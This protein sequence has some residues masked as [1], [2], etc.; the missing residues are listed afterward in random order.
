MFEFKSFRKFSKEIKS[1]ALFSIYD[2]FC[3]TFDSKTFVKDMFKQPED[4]D[5]MLNQNDIEKTIIKYVKFIPS[6]NSFMFEENDYKSMYKELVFFYKERIIEYLVSME[7]I[8]IGWN[9][10]NVCFITN[11]IIIA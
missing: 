6:T 8:V 9:N 10:D 2:V 7:L 3:D 5:Y 1:K 4:F 11:P